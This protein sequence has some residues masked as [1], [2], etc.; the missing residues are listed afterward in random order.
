MT[1]KLNK[2]SLSEFAKS[3]TSLNVNGFFKTLLYGEDNPVITGSYIYKKLIRGEKIPDVDIVIRNLHAFK[4][5]FR[6]HFKYFTL[7]YPF[8]GL[9]YDL[10]RSDGVYLDVISS[11][12]YIATV[13]TN[14]LTT[15]NSLVYSDGE[16]KHICELDEMRDVFSSKNL[17]VEREKLWNIDN[18]RRG[19]YCKW[20]TM[21]DKD[22]EYFNTFDIIDLKECMD[23]H[24]YPY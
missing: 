13:H 22:I 4:K 14:G 1:D 9:R 5:I 15:I 12:D 3:I 18:F 7:T 17:D 8:E 24:I 21:R 2:C 16:I 11:E 10:R 20:S 6:K 19:R 23:H